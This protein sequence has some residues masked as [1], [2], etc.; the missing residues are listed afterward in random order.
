MKN[1]KKKMME[2][3]NQLDNK[4][5][6]KTEKTSKKLT[7]TLS[8]IVLMIVALII[9]FFYVIASFFYYEIYLAFSTEEEQLIIQLEKMYNQNIEI[10]ETNC[11]EKAN[12]TYVLRTTKEPKIE[13]HAVKEAYQDFE[14]DYEDRLFIYYKEQ[15]KNTLFQDM[16]L[17]KQEEV[18]EKYPDFPLLKCQAYLSIEDYSQIELASRNLYQIQQFLESKVEDFEVLTY[19]KIGDDYVSPVKYNTIHSEE[20]GI[21]AE[22]YEYYWHLKEID[23]D[24]SKIPTSDIKTLNYPRTLEVTV[25]GNKVTDSEESGYGFIYYLEANYNLEKRAYEIDAR[26]LIINNSRYFGVRT[27]DT[28]TAFNFTYQ[29]KTYGIHFRDDKIRG[30]NLPWTCELSYFT[31]LLGIQVEYDLEQGK[32]NFVLESTY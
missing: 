1:E 7:V 13:F 12:G 21:Y 4:Q 14:T 9:A 29:G 15:Q 11:D 19:L 8:T 26:K 30:N 28:H 16:Q 3:I 31:Q 17:M 32:V 27:S 6:E 25:N 22:K 2:Y 20:H 10:V 23:G 5:M 18:N 24:I